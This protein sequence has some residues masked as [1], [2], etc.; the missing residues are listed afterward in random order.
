MDTVPWVVGR[1]QHRQAAEL[2]AQ[3]GAKVEVELMINGML[4]AVFAALSLEGDGF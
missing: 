1:E 3:T 4:R 2:F